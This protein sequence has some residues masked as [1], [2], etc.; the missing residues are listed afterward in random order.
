MTCGRRWS[1]RQ[2]PMATS[3]AERASCCAEPTS[4]LWATA[5]SASSRRH[6]DACRP[7]HPRAG[8]HSASAQHTQRT[9]Y[10]AKHSARKPRTRHA[11]TVHTP[12][13]RRAC[14]VSQ[15]SNVSLMWY[16]VSVTPATYLS[17]TSLA[18]I[19]PP[20]NTTSYGAPFIGTTTLSVNTTYNTSTY[21]GPGTGEVAQS[22]PFTYYDRTMPPVVASLHP[23]HAPIHGR[24]LRLVGGWELV[25][26]GHWEDYKGAEVHGGVMLIGSNFVPTHF[27]WCAFRPPPARP[28]TTHHTHTHAHAPRPR[29]RP[30]PRPFPLPLP[31]AH[32]RPRPRPCPNLG[33]CAFAVPPAEAS[34]RG[35]WR[36]MRGVYMN[37]TAVR[38]EVPHGVNGDFQAA[39]VGT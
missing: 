21:G 3:A 18:C 8:I 24:S 25:D 13:T 26:H 11:H 29:P 33:R 17:P 5:S 12:R 30:R 20:F 39:H 19:S 38:C 36:W 9:A 37:A 15:E 27:L 35:A 14:N 10:T 1:R 28:R 6:S 34:T 23:S 16:N 31:R 7:G 22:V 2:R 32:P 4:R